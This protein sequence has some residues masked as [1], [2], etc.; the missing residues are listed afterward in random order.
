VRK[1]LAP[2]QERKITIPAEYQTIT[3]TEMVSD[4]SMEWRRI[5]CETNVNAS[6]IRQVQMSLRDAGHNPGPIDGVIGYQTQAALKSYQRANNLA[7][8]GLTYETLRHM[9]ISL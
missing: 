8:G 3:R 4:G 5:L 6:I 9:N 7:E 1:M 2:E